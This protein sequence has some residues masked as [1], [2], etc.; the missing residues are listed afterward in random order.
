MVLLAL[1]AF[2][3]PQEEPPEHQPPAAQQ[4]ELILGRSSAAN[5]QD[6]PES[7]TIVLEHGGRLR[8]APDLAA[9]LLEIVAESSPVAV[10]ER[11]EG[12]A[13]VR[14]G[15]WKGWVLEAGQDTGLLMTAAPL[16]RQE[17][18]VKLARAREL[19]GARARETTLGPYRL[20]TDLGADRLNAS[21]EQLV[22]T[23]AD[24]Y[25][26]R[27]GLDPGPPRD[28]VIVIFERE[29]EYR[30]FE[31]E[32]LR[33]AGL[34][35][36]GYTATALLAETDDPTT[37]DVGTLIVTYLGDR[38]PQLLR[39]ILVHEL[40]HMLNRRAVGPYLPP[41]L[42]EGLA[43]DLALSRVDASGHLVLGSWGGSVETRAYAWNPRVSSLSTSLTGSRA[44]M[45][46]LLHSWRS[47]YRPELDLLTRLSWEMLVTPASRPL[48]YAQ[49][50][51]LTRYLLDGAGDESSEIFRA[52][53]ADVAGGELGSDALWTR[54][55][56]RPGQLEEDFYLWLRRRA[57]ALGI[58]AP[59]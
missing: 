7:D 38:H 54:L 21:L 57:D 53:L 24:S 42:E 56:T 51:F 34:E 17:E 59:R 58:R 39:E 6:Q 14:F 16:D 50:A 35:T 11:Y 9:P 3:R 12:W 22:T 46:A 44:A 55:D 27:F 43:E 10:L 26:E 5:F 1:A 23:L 33:L 25:R 13:R 49:S 37:D 4:E 29:D 18:L 47:P 32:D 52:Y 2:A 48:L 45:G 8:L 15:I 19:L 40:T 36:H 28:E 31:R 30:E 20:F 41:W